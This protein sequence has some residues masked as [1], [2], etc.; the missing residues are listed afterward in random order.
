M[1]AGSPF[2]DTLFD[3]RARPGSIA[4]VRPDGSRHHIDTARWHRFSLADDDVLARAAG[5]VLDVGCG[6]GRHVAE[7]AR[8]GHE[9]LGLDSSAA[10]VREAVRRGAPAVHGSVFGSV[11]RAGEWGTV[12]LLDGNVGIGGDPAA[13]LRQCA[14]LLRPGGR[15][16]VETEPPGRQGCVGPVR[17]EPIESRRPNMARHR[18]HPN[19]WF[20]WATIS[21][22]QIEDVAASAGF[23]VIEIWRATNRWFASLC[24]RRPHLSPGPPA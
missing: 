4:L 10:A 14:A 9:A 12:L 19:P 24:L 21:A 1:K 17:V 7:L 3:R 23:S 20:S 11:P 5:P 13:L 6:P 8:R 2:P 18:G 15:L 16:L 22:S